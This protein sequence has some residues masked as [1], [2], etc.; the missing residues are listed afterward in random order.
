MSLKQLIDRARNKEYFTTLEAYVEFAKEFIEFSKKGFEARIVSQNENH[1]FFY[2]Y[3]KDANYNVTRPINSRLMLGSKDAVI[4]ADFI[5]L[6]SSIKG[7]KKNKKN[8]EI[9]NKSVYTLQQSIGITLD[10]LPSG[11]SNTARKLNGDLFESLIKMI[12]TKIGL[13]CS[14]QTVRIPIKMKGVKKFDMKYQHDFVLKTGGGALKAIGSI[15]TSSKD[16]IDKIFIDKFLY[17]Q[18]AKQSVPH[19]A[20]FLNDVQRK[21]S[22]KENEYSIGHTFLPDRFKGYT[23]KLCPLDGVYYCDLRPE[24]GNDN[25]L[26][27]HIFSLDKLLYDDIWKWVK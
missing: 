16:R 1:Y 13:D 8:R 15:K 23:I 17:N 3:K 2:Q 7:A 24:V 25:L 14:T 5:K 18:L 12:I 22:K 26:K 9:I 11:K 4:L 10:A 27:K 20:I 21:K 6:L 19:I